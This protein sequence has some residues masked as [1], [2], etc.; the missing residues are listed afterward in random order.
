MTP[1]ERA[2]ALVRLGTF[3]TDDY[4]TDE[5]GEEHCEKVFD[6][7]E[8]RDEIASAVREAVSEEREECAKV[9]EEQT[10]YPDTHTG[11]RQQWVKDQIAAA[12]R[13]RADQ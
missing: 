12:I 10:Y 11:T 2:D 3:I 8:L 13:A 1:K 9:A 6:L 5:D 7:D 4:H